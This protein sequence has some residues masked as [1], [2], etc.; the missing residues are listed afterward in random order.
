MGKTSKD[1]VLAVQY[2]VYLVKRVISLVNT[3]S[4]A[5]GM[6]LGKTYQV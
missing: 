2:W 3:C 4:T 6:G 1:M 5:K